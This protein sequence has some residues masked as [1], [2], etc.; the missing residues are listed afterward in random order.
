MSF[1][2]STY[3]VWQ[4]YIPF[5]YLGEINLIK[6][7]VILIFCFFATILFNQ[8]FNKI[9][10]VFLLVLLVFLYL[11]VIV[12]SL[13]ERRDF[14]I[15][16]LLFL[17]SI[18]I[19]YFIISLPSK[20]CFSKKLINQFPEEKKVFKS[21]LN[22]V[23]FLWIISA[24]FIIYVYK[25]IIYFA[26]LDVIYDQRIVGA[27]KNLA[28]GYLQT[29][30][31]Y[32]LSIAL[33][34]FGLFLGKKFYIVLGCFGCVLLYGVTAERSIILMPLFA[35][36]FYKFAKNH[37]KS[38]KIVFYFL[39]ISGLY[40]IFAG[41][42]GDYNKLFKDIS[43]YYLTRVVATPGLLVF[44]YYDFF[45]EIGYTFYSHVKGFNIFF[46]PS[47]PL[48]VDEFY[49]ALGKIIARDLYEVN[50]NMNASFLATD[51]AAALGLLGII[52]ISCVL[53]IALFCF[54]YVSFGWPREI[55]YPLMAQLA[56]LLTNGSFFTMMF[57]FGGIFWFIFFL[58][59]KLNLK[60]KSG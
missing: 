35:Y 16:Y 30:F 7:F 32:V 29:Y 25:S 5:F 45:S 43:F 31:G 39:L 37:E 54:N 53:S 26:S 38:I 19:S 58:L 21:Y 10:D 9:S 56:F 41:F 49:P 14:S 15:E 2:H 44:D 47:Y 40:F 46:N 3:L 28:E 59:S 36:I 23:F 1:A 4:D 48:A 12:I 22:F 17:I 18:F 13:G 11:P 50:S 27:A 8:K 52:I 24:F 57:S 34:V 60:K 6:A 42:F 55:T 51:G 33:V 20:I